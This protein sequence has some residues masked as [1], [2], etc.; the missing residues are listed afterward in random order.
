MKF[1]MYLMSWTKICITYTAAAFDSVANSYDF[2]NFHFWKNMS[3]KHWS[4]YK[5]VMLRMIVELGKNRENMY[6]VCVKEMTW[7]FFY[8]QENS[9]HKTE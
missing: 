8:V 2:S 5:K 4:L 7:I 1:S 3:C 6:S 9:I